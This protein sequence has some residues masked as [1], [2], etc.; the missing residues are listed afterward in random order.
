MKKIIATLLLSVIMLTLLCSCGGGGEQE[1]QEPTTK[2]RVGYLTGPTGM[3]M[4]KL[5]H[6]NGGIAGNEKYEFISYNT[7]SSFAT[8]DLSNGE[9]DI[10]CLATN[11]A[12][13]Y[14]SSADSNLRIL[15]VNC[16]NSLYLVSDENNQVSS[17]ADLQGKT[18]YTCKNGTPAI[19]LEY[20]INALGYNIDVLYSINGT[21]LD[22]P[23][24]VRNQIIAGNIPYAVIPEPIVTASLLK[25]SNY[26]IDINLA[27]EWANI[28]GLEN[29]PVTMGCIVTSQKFIDK[30]PELIAS[31]LN[32]YKESVNYIGNV[33]NVE[34][35]ANYVAES[36][37][38][39]AAP[40]AKKAISN[41]GN[42]I[43]YLDGEEMKSALIAFYT[44]IGMTLPDDNFYY[45]K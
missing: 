12:L 30:N 16:L 40:A 2:I 38:M 22:T 19:I 17:F 29:T 24:D 23:A 42:A 11:E 26:S 34:N 33:E 6:D 32:E 27:D 4:A 36:K 35:S 39:D 10:I 3:G 45:G 25:N 7:N 9:V 44:A 31:F 37:I 15:A 28:P 18:I 13:K 1:N 21:K 41:L 14:Y 20:I 43:A 5:I 8:A